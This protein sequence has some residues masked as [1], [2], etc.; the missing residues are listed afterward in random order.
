MNRRIG[1]LCLAAAASWLVGCEN[2]SASSAATSA[3]ATTAA[4]TASATATAA[5]A[6]PAANAGPVAPRFEVDPFWPKP[7]PNHWVLGSTIGV[8]VDSRDHVWIIHRHQ[9]LNAETEASAGKN[10][11]AGECCSIA[12]PVLEFD[13]AGNFVSSWGGPGD[14]YDWP[15][16]NHG[17]TVDHMDN[18]W[19]GGND[20]ADAH[21]LKFSRTGQFL[22]QLGKPKHEP[23]Q[24]R[25]REFLAR[26]E[27]LDRLGRERGVRGRRLR[28]QARGR[29]RREHRRAQAV[30]G[31]VRQHAR[32]YGPGAIRSRCSAGAAIQQAP[33]TARSRHSTVSCTYATASTIA[34]RSFVRTALS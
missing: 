19:I 21:I 26:R 15:T 7:L 5:A 18:I 24:Q 27:D 20:M 31:R 4:A 14:G 9:T 2:E 3:A 6:A 12:P 34:F 33:C 16:S 25:S 1:S 29:A 10:T 30:L 28:Q 17:I 11:P 23:R 22:L 8:S 13:A 32:R